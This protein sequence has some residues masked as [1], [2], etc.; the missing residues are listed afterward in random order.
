MSKKLLATNITKSGKASKSSKVKAGECQF[1]FIH[2]G[3][4]QNECLVVE[5]FYIRGS[6]FSTFAFLFF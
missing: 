6:V 2:K 1:P 5:T 3:Q 4:L